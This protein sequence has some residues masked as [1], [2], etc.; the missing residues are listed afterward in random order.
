MKQ[1]NGRTANTNA[2]GFSLYLSFIVTCFLLPTQPF[3]KIKSY[4]QR[5]LFKPL[6]TASLYL[7]CFS[8]QMLRS[9]STAF[10][11]RWVNSHVQNTF[12]GWKALWVFLSR[13]QTVR[14]RYWILE[15]NKACAIGY[16]ILEPEQRPSTMEVSDLSWVRYPK[17]NL[18][19]PMPLLPLS[20]NSAWAQVVR[21][22]GTVML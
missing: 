9:Q 12:K 6:P 2:T 16:V 20:W 8:G 15:H 17:G 21:V 18:R 4:H 3:F 14:I 19:L 13:V 7:F 11:C 22:M 1:K 10:R 5:Y